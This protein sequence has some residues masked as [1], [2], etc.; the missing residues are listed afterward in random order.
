MKDA[1][2][3]LFANKQMLIKFAGWGSLVDILQ[4]LNA[5]ITA[6]IQTLA[7]TDISFAKISSLEDA[8]LSKFKIPKHQSYVLCRIVDIPS[9]I[10]NLKKPS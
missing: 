2:F 7:G 10:I 6:E 1:V 3:V 8:I 5:Y 9:D 4:A